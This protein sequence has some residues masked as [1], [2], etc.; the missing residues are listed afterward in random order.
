MFPDFFAD[1]PTISVVDPLAEVLGAA[2]SGRMDYH[3]ADAVRLAGHSCPTVAGAWLMARRGLGALYPDGLPV[4]GQVRVE[5]RDDLSSG[6]TGVVA[7]VLG[8]VIG[9]AGEGGFKGLGGRFARNGLVTGGVAMAGEVRL[10]R[11]DTGAQVELTYQAQSVP[12]DPV[13]LPLMQRV[14]KGEADAD[15]RR[16]FAGLWQ[17][18]VRRL[19]IE[20]ADDP[21]VVR[22]I[23]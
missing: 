14:T 22:L 2:V 13:M 12:P 4:R 6:T 8:L 17:D 18:R 11:L 16:V 1:V 9:A 15:E 23:G 20:H 10:T 3:Y 7:A 21:A 19:L 5:L